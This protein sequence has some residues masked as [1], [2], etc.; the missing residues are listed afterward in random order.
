MNSTFGSNYFGFKKVQQANLLPKIS[1]NNTAK[2]PTHKY[3]YD[4][5]RKGYSL[6]RKKTENNAKYVILKN[7]T[8]ESIK[9]VIYYIHGGNYV[10]GLTTTYESLVYPLC[11]ISD[12]I[13]VILLDYSLAPNYKYPTQ[14]DEAFDVWNE[15]T[16]EFTPEDII[17]GGDS[18]GGHLALSLVEKIQKDKNESPKSAFF[19]S[20]WIDMTCSGKS[21]FTNYQKDIVLGD[22]NKPL[23]K[24][25]LEELKN[26]EMFCFIG[27]A[28]RNDPYVSPLFGDYTK[29]PNSLFIVGDNEILLDDTLNMVKKLKENGHKVKLYK[30]E[31]MSHNFP[32]YLN[33]M[34]DGFEAF[35]TIKDFIV[36]SFEFESM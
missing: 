7:E 18:S 10:K 33:F 22:P 14:L 25:N 31:G 28:N 35:I 9:K 17:I 11:D 26:S 34:Q 4:N 20:P 5:I 29:F 3:L 30:K 19:I 12:D 8:E 32:L 27:Y 2:I 15:L 6:T 36:D 16:K 1:L 13:Q 24:E 23:T 21:Y